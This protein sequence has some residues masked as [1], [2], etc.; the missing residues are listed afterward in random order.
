VKPNKGSLIDAVAPVNHALVLGK[1][2][3]N[4]PH[5]GLPKVQTIPTENEDDF[6]SSSDSF[7]DYSEAPSPRVSEQNHQMLIP[8]FDNKSKPQES[9]TSLVL[10]PFGQFLISP[11]YH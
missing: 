7:S 4:L 6:D 2:S 10:K 3:S 5:L 11:D 9:I 8:K 1:K